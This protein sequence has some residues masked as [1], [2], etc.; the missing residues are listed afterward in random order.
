MGPLRKRSKP[1]PAK[2]STL[3]A[4][5]LEHQPSSVSNNANPG[6]STTEGEQNS[7]SISGNAEENGSGS[8]DPS[9]VLKKSHSSSAKEVN[10]PT[11]H[12]I[13][14]TN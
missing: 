4:A 5:T 11:L 13:V 9:A 14:L 7:L 6:V 1:N 8:L 2:S 10:S 12:F 3:G